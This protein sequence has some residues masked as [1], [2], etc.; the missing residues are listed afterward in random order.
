[1]L[2][3]FKDFSKESY[4]EII[5]KLISIL[6]EGE[7]TEVALNKIKNGLRDVREGRVVSIENYAKRRGIKLE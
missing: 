3:Y 4:D 2:K 7:L 1:K 5:N 6:E